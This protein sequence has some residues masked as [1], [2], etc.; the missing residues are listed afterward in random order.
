ML[1]KT[2]YAVV[3][4]DLRQAAIA[5]AL[6]Q[7]CRRAQVC[8]M[9][10]EK[11]TEL[12]SAEIYKTNDISQVF[13][14]AAVI[15]FPLPVSVDGEFISAPFSEK[16]LPFDC[17]KYINK[18]AQVFAGAVSQAFRDTASKYNIKLW[19]YFER[20]ELAILNAV[21][22]A[23]GAVEIALRESPR[24]LFGQS[25]LITGYGRVAKA[26]ARLLPA[27]GAKTAV[28]ARSFRDLARAAADGLE[29]V[30]MG[31][32][33]NRLPQADIIFNT[34]PSNILTQS[35]LE[36][37]PG[38]CLIIDLASKPGGLDFGAARELGLKVIWA[39]SLPGKVAPITAG[40][41]I[42]ETIEN[43]IAEKAYCYANEMEL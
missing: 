7:K 10:M 33:A 43:I 29:T 1:C 16:K 35:L 32:L 26:V 21:P 4:G 36:K 14:K 40:E 17:L 11:E 2:L 30:P 34:V 39:L 37:V 6:V 8:G 9:F 23:E 13:P 20:E 22:T 31:T 5:N 24:T 25:C 15:I 19:D 27:F 12:S 3:G 42:L 28:A 18:D 38:D 41:I